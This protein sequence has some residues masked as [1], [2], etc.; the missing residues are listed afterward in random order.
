MMPSMQQRPL[1]F[2]L[3]QS[4]AAADRSL[5]AIEMPFSA[6]GA[7][8]IAHHTSSTAGLYR[9]NVNS[10]PTR[11]D[12]VGSKVSSGIRHSQRPSVLPSSQ[13]C[14]EMR[15]SRQLSMLV[16]R[17]MLCN[18]ELSEL[19]KGQQSIVSRLPI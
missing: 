12:A 17:G 3:K 10:M 7:P 13:R 8:G 1:S 16:K 11:D 9:A 18:R 19:L 2:W 14:P 4:A 6:D 5:I 15:W